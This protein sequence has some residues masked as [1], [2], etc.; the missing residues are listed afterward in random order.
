MEGPLTDKYNAVKDL[1][2]KQSRGPAKGKSKDYG[3]MQPRRY[4]FLDPT[5]MTPRSIDT[6]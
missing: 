6:V 3:T 1:I 4:S 5:L 2:S